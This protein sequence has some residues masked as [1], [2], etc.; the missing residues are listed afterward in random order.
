M[1]FNNVVAN[2]L[3]IPES[4]TLRKNL[5]QL[6]ISEKSPLILA[7]FVVSCANIK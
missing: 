4:W 5:Q 7:N 1:Q 2:L 3:C 6:L